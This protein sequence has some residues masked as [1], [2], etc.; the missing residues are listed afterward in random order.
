MII[1]MQSLKHTESDLKNN[2]EEDSLDCEDDGYFKRMPLI[3]SIKGEI[4]QV[5]DRHITRTMEFDEDWPVSY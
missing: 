1:T 4:N 2:Q 5:L 3:S